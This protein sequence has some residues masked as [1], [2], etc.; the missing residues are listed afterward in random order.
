MVL[1][2]IQW[3]QFHYALLTTKNAAS[4]L[5]LDSALLWNCTGKVHMSKLSLHL[6][7][8]TK[9]VSCGATAGAKT[10]IANI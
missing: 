6:E 3:I 1:D 7:I 2:S 4:S 9:Q 5:I 10:S 8:I